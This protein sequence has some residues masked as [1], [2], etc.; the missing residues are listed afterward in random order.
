M[1]IAEAIGFLKISSNEGK[2]SKGIEEEG[3]GVLD[4]TLGL[5]TF[6][7]FP[8]FL[9]LLQQTKALLAGFRN[10]SLQERHFLISS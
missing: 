7:F 3:V 2:S 9:H 1:F 5:T 8:S 4:W 6:G 10:A